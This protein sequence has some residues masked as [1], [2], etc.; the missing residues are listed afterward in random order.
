MAYFEVVSH[1]CFGQ[2]QK[3]YCQKWWFRVKWIFFSNWHL[4]RNIF[5]NLFKT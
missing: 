4:Y 1:K 5:F 2:C 3:N